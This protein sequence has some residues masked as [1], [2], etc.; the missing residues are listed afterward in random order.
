MKKSLIVQ[1]VLCFYFAAGA[2]PISLCRDNPHYFFYNGKPTVLIT[3]AEHYGAVINST[4]EYKKYFDV[5]QQH[6]FNLTRI[7]T[8][9]YLESNY[10]QDAPDSARKLNWEEEQNTLS[11]RPGKLI[12]PWARSNVQGYINS[13]NKFDLDRWDAQYFLRLRDFCREASSRGIV[14]EIVLFSANYSPSNWMNSPLNQQNNVNQTEDVP[15]NQVYLSSYKKL[16]AYQLTMVSKIVDE[17][18]PFDNVYYEICNEPYWLK[19]IPEVDPSVHEQQV[20]PE[21]YKW[22]HAIAVRITQTEQKLPKKHLIAQ[23]FANTYMKVENMDNVVSILNFHYAYPPK[24]VTDNLSLNKPISFDETNEGLNTAEKRK[25]AWAFMMAGGA[26]YN[27][28]DWSFA[29]D[30]MTGMGLNTSGRKRIGT[31]VWDQ[32]EVLQKA[33]AD[34]SFI[35]ATPLDTTYKISGI[36]LYGLGIKGKD[37]MMYCVKSKGGYPKIWNCSLPRGK[38]LI[39]WI[40]P[41]NGEITQRKIVKSANDSAEITVPTFDKDQVLRIKRL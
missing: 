28:L 19:G 24:T 23:N 26:V 9:S 1:V 7:F 3:S 35:K 33:M 17:L 32:L 36:D 40:D 30:D 31:D 38:Y 12:A 14:V 22:Q 8:G 37:Y 2:Q 11:V 5:L 10:Y 20:T 34:Y 39:K 29:N 16:A 4:P 25:E 6:H 21:I 15:Y 41:S 13:G 27:N 18:N